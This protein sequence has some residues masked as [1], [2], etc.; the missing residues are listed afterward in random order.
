MVGVVLGLPAG[1]EAVLANP[2]RKLDLAE[3][4]MVV[5]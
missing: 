4:D 3:M 1:A 5:S 2:D